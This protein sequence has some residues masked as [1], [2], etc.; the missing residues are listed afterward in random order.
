M[1]SSAAGSGRINEAEVRARG[2]YR[3]IMECFALR[4]SRRRRDP[5]TPLIQEIS[6][7]LVAHPEKVW[8]YEGARAEVSV[9]EGVFRSP[10]WRDQFIIRTRGNRTELYI[11][12]SR[13]AND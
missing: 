5:L 4:V 11:R 1:E 10:R 8:C 12:T 6:A 3:S 9:L 7:E 2:S 13:G